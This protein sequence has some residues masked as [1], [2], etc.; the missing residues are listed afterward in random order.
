MTD[1]NTIKTPQAVGAKL[2]KNA[3][4]PE[5]GQKFL[6]RELMGA[7]T[8]AALAT[9]PDIAHVVSSLAQFNCD[10]NATHWTAAK[11]VF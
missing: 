3:S 6:Y 11:R 5:N 9:R 10:P 8:Y 4:K 1:C 7:F 2:M